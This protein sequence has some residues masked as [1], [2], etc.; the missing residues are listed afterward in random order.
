MW[1]IPPIP[2]KSD[3]TNTQTQTQTPNSPL[4]H[5]IKTQGRLS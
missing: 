4:E 2:E 1:P 5:T 3:D